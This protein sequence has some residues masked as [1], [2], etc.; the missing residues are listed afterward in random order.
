MPLGGLGAIGEE[1]EDTFAEEGEDSFDLSG[2]VSSNL[3]GGRRSGGSRLSTKWRTGVAYYAMAPLAGAAMGAWCCSAAVMYAAATCMGYCVQA[4][5]RFCTAFGPKV[6]ID[7]CIALVT[8]GS[9][10]IGEA[11]AK[12]LAQ[13]G[14]TVV[15]WGRDL[16]NLRRVQLDIRDAGGKCLYY[17]C[18]LAKRENVLKAADLML[19][20]VGEPDIVVLNAGIASGWPIASDSDE[21]QDKA[22]AVNLSSNLWMVKRFWPGMQARGYG[23]FVLV[24]SQSALSQGNLYGIT[25]SPSCC[26]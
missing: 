7:G 1:S 10:G 16:D 12:A 4:V 15:I 23:H 20:D 22:M 24:S 19:K 25:V 9:L 26:V 8:G 21:L 13:K 3:M 2:D 14:G 11:V 18:D 6:D 17:T 5:Q